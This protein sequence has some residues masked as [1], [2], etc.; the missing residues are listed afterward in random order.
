MSATRI[1]TVH[2]LAWSAADDG[3]AILVKE[4]FSW[5]GFLFGG[6]FALWH[7]MW[8]AAATLFALS[9]L[10]GFVTEL[11]GL[12]DT[13]AGT[14]QLVLQLGAGLF[15]NDMRRWSLRRDG[16]V[17][18]AVVAAPNRTAAEFRYFTALAAE[19]GAGAARLSSAGGA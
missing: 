8:V 7:G 1:Y 11:A 13:L 5:P 2:K 6:F 14:L 16:F 3:D 4:G 9:F 18:T 17:E 19:P 15:G 12:G 10:L